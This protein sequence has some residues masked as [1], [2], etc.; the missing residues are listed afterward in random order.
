M[1]AS[2]IFD[3]WPER[4]DNWFQTPIGEQIKTYET[5]LIMEMLRPSEGELILDAGCGTGIFTKDFISA[6]TKVVGLDL[7]LPMLVRAGEKLS[8]SR[9]LMSQGDME[10]LPFADHV[11]DKTDTCIVKCI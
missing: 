7:S 6:G 5:E 11:F 10:R 8:G 2:K 4:Y 3:P 1:K 9:F